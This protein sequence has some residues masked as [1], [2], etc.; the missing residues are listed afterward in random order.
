MRP[1]YKFN[2]LWI[3]L[4]FFMIASNLI[5]QEQSGDYNYQPESGQEGKDVIWVPT[6]QVLVDKMLDMAKVTPGDY[7]MDLGS[8]DGRLVITAAKRGA[9]ALGIEYNQEMVD[10]S[11]QNAS[12]EGVSSKAK[13]LQADLFETDLSKATVIT[14]FLLPGLNL[15]LRPRLLELKPGTRIVSNTFTMEEWEPDNSV[16]LDYDCDSWCNAYLWIIPAKAEGKW[17]L[18]EGELIIKQEF[19]KISG[20]FK[21]GNSSVEISDGRLKGSEIKFKA[22]GADYTGTLSGN[23]IE[24]ICTIGRDAKK[25]TATR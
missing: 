13:F 5:A 3:V 4:S 16:N 11:I 2:R 18:N 8:G 7:L 25:W 20:I 10:L 24:G 1:S 22:N 9:S 17:K 21:N 14:L 19:Q 6:P 23:K 12:K 15:K